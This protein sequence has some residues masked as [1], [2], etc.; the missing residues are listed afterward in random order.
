MVAHGACSVGF[1]R[2]VNDD[3]AVRGGADEVGVL[4]V[5]AADGAEAVVEA[6]AELDGE[7]ARHGKRS[8]LRHF[9]FFF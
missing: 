6:G 3:E 8:V 5:E 1:G 2:V 9:F 7:G 4:A